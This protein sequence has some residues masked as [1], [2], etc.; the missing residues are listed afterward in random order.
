MGGGGGILGG[1]TQSIFG[2]PQTVSTPNYSQAAQDT[3][4]A[5]LANAQNATNA[6]RVNQ[7]TPYGNLSYSQTTDAQGNPVWTANQTLPSGLQ[8]AIGGNFGVMANTYNNPLT[9]PTFN[10]VG[11]MPSM[12]YFGSRLNQQQFNP[13]T[14][15]QSLPQ[16]NVNTQINQSK[17]PT[18]GINPGQSYEQGIMARLQPAIE[19]DRQSLS[20]QL[21][22]QGIVPGTKAYETAMTLQSQK[23]N[24][25]RTSAVVGGMDT[26]LRANQQVFGQQAGQIGLNLTGQ[27]QS[28]TQPLRV[29]AQNMSANDLAYQQQ[30]A[31]QQ[32]G[33]GAQNQAFTQALAKYMAP[34]QVGSLLKGIAAPNQYVT[35]YNQQATGGTDYLSAMGLTQQSNQANANAQNAQNNALLSGLFTLGGASLMSPTGTFTK[36]FSDIRM[37]ENIELIGY[38]AN[39]LNVYD[40]EYKPEYKD[41]AGHGRFRG[42][43]AQEVEKVIPYAVITLDDGYKMVDYS[44]LGA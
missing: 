42:V 44:L 38:M 8:S 15:L 9:S 16:Y 41:T 30:L 34:A 28:F 19:R 10:S 31:N 21:A 37:K 43:M 11:D 22:N 24:D 20:A 33:M 39:G 18:F 5:N 3:A 35:P 32:L 17:L 14:Q 4:A 27:E 12:N 29:N 26:G 36:M 25:A 13:A 40:F 23:E 2:K 1:I 7:N 6:N